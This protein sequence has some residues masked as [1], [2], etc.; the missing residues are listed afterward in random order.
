MEAKTVTTILETGKE[1]TIMVG[2]PKIAAKLFKRETFI[3]FRE[4]IKL[5]VLFCL[6]VV[7]PVV[8]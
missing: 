8:F 4:T 3:E 2:R 5:S 6:L 1:T 7:F